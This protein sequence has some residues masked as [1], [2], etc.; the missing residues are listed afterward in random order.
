MATLK[1]QEHLLAAGYRGDVGRFQEIVIEIFQIGYEGWTDEELLCR[2]EDAL[3]Y[4]ARVRKRA[5]APNIPDV[6][7][8][9]TLTNL[10]KRSAIRGK[11]ER[12]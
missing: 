1:L 6:V 12:E 4:C 2:P 7:I 3:A 10:R 9:R 11:G 5:R 8:L